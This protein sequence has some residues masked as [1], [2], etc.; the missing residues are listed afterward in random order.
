MRSL[1][2]HGRNA[3]LKVDADADAAARAVLRAVEGLYL[4]EIMSTT[5]ISVASAGIDGGLPWGP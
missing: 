2:N 1:G 4:I 3:R 5:K